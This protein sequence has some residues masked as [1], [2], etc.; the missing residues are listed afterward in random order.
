MPLAATCPSALVVASYNVHRCV[1]LD[2]RHDPDRVADVIRDLEADVVALQELDSRY[3]IEDGLDQIVY[4]AATTGYEAIPGPVRV[5]ALGNYGNGLLLRRPPLAVRRIDLSVRG[6]EE[7]G[8]LDVDIDVDGTEVRVVAAHLGLN[9]GERRI[10]VGRLLDALAEHRDRPLVLLG[11]FN[12]WMRGTP[13][14]R[15]LNR[16]FGAIPSLRTFPSRFPVFALDRIWVQPRRAIRGLV[17]HGA[18]AAR[19]AS[20]HLPI[21]AVLDASIG[22]PESTARSVQP[23]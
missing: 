19:V 18:G 10:Q 22:S 1:G 12:E 21:R 23:L 2:G 5:R 9:A 3:H 15:R 8:A 16:R 7:R 4:L 17:V 6:R 13:L 11:D 20:D 14:L